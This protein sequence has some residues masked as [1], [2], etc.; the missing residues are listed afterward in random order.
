MSTFVAA[1]V[2]QSSVELHA[3]DVAEVTSGNLSQQDDEVKT[4]IGLQ[5]ILAEFGLS[6]SQV[7]KLR[8]RWGFPEPFLPGRRA[9]YCRSEVE[10]WAREQPCQKNLA[11]IL[12]CRKNNYRPRSGKCL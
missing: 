4:A 8:Q 12:R 2:E 10:S 9:L 1:T 3:S 5:D 11:I 7:R 6:T